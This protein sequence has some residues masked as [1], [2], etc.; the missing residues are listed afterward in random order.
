[1]RRT[2]R[3]RLAFLYG[4]VFFASG[5]VLLG[6]RLC[7]RSGPDKSVPRDGAGA[8]GQGLPGGVSIAG[9]STA[10]ICTCC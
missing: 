3:M 7:R 9:S 10:P 6:I 8:G 2:L 1:M 5:T 4:G